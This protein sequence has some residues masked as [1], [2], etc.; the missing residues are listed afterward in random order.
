MKQFIPARGRKP[1]VF[2]TS[3]SGSLKQF[4]P[5]RGRKLAY[6]HYGKIIGETIHP[7]KG[8]ETRRLA[9]INARTGNNSSPQGDGNSRLKRNSLFSSSKQFIPARGRK[10]APCTTCEPQHLKQFIPARGRKP[11]IRA[12][13][14]QQS[15]ETI[16][17]R[18]GTETMS[19]SFSINVILK[20]F[21]PARGRKHWLMRSTGRA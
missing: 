8:T 3:L 20:Q 21:I 17:P 4:I 12:Q 16:H 10:H 7:R 18:T 9:V 11:R 15:K 19:F 5:A 13:N 1:C 6:P 14:F 2:A